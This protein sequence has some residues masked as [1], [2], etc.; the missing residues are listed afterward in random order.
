MGEESTQQ[1]EQTVAGDPN[2]AG[3]RIVFEYQRLKTI[4]QESPQETTRDGDTHIVTDGFLT[5]NRSSEDGV[6]SIEKIRGGQVDWDKDYYMKPTT[7]VD[8]DP[9][10]LDRISVER[11]MERDGKLL[12]SSSIIYREYTDFAIDDHFLVIEKEERFTEY[13]DAGTVKGERFHKVNAST[14][15]MLKEVNRN[16]G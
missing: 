7:R 3:W 11:R 10:T 13:S 9:Y 16:V 4:I 15:E 1:T 8:D 2:E 14:G 6:R 12:S 5:Q